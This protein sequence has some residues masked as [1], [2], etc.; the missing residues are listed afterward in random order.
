MKER[1][2][3]CAL[4]GK[5][6]AMVFGIKGEEK[7]WKFTCSDQ[8]YNQASSK[9]SKGQAIKAWNNEQLRIYMKAKYDE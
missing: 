2:S 4:C 5:F 8:C 1:I 6:P 9:I 3:Q 7:F